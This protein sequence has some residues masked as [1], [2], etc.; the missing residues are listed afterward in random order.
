[1][2]VKEHG[3]LKLVIDHSRE[4]LKLVIH[5]LCHYQQLHAITKNHQEQCTSGI[6][7]L[8]PLHNLVTRKDLFDL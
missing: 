2:K 1:M 7:L 4:I 3:Y 6:F 5:N 8:L